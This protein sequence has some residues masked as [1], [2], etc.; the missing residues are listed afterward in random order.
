MDIITVDQICSATGGELLSGDRNAEIYGVCTD[1]R[2]FREGDLFVALLGAAADAHRFIP[3]VCE[4]GGKT[5]L[6]SER[7]AA[8]G[9]PDCNMI[10][11]E[12]TLAGLQAL[13]KAYLDRINVGRIAVTGSVGK[14][15]TRD[16]IYYILSERYKTGKPIA[17]YNSDVGLPLTIFTFD[18]STD[19]AVL[20]MGMEHLGEIHRLAKMTL[21]EV[22]VIT[23]IGVSHLENVGSR[24]NILKAKMEI[25]DYFGSGNVLIVNHDNDMLQTLKD[26]QEYHLIT[27]GSSGDEDYVVSDVEDMGVEG[28]SFRL[29]CEEGS[30]QFTLPIP[31]AHN[32]INAGLAIAA[33]SQYDISLEEAA[34]G[35]AKMELTGRRLKVLTGNGVSVLDDSY[36]AAPDSVKSALLTLK[37]SPAT[38]RIAILGNM[39][40]LGDETAKM[41]YEVGRFAAECG[42]DLIIGI[43][44]KAADIV[45]GARDAGADALYFETKEDLYP[46]L[47]EL[48]REGDLVL[49]KASMTRHFWEIAERIIDR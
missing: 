29:T 31:G 45:A 22:A 46:Q 7:D 3:Q 25:T 32:A 12:D 17:N 16:M 2:K 10:L 40:E 20:E 23:N 11:V 36:N 41:H 35:L 15:S 8:A 42:M 9:H 49:C 1:S 24:E 34:A 28:I 48:I 21:P 43:E 39:N 14:T 38:R 27:V 5:F 13:T 37:A 33:C 30:R 19:M 18:S 47:D 26:D 6:I 4:K 44:S